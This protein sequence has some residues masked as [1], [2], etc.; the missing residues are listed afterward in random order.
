M[1]LIIKSFHPSDK[2]DKF[3][4]D[5]I[6]TINNKQNN[7]LEIKDTSYEHTMQL[8]KV[9]FYDGYNVQLINIKDTDNVVMYI[10]DGNF[11]QR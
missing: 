5:N 2:I 4:N 6:G 11:R 1:N 9:A 3:I 7:S 10:D 8:A